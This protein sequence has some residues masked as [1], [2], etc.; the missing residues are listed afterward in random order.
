MNLI[1]KQTPQ[2]TPEP[3]PKDDNEPLQKQDTIEIPNASA[4]TRKLPLINDE[5][6]NHLTIMEETDTPVLLLSRNF[7]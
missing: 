5:I 1:K 2:N 7:T 3:L 4:L 6:Q